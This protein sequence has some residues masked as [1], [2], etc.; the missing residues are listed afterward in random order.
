VDSE[1]RRRAWEASDSRLEINVPLVPKIF[2]LR[3]NIAKIMGYDTWADYIT[4]VKMVKSAQNALDVR[5]CYSACDL[6]VLIFLVSR[7]L[8]AEAPPS[9][10]Q[11]T[12]NITISQTSRMR[13]KGPAI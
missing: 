8:R 7:R 4:E 10:P 9:G 6:S 5:L 2:G 11:R 1:T 3:R 13:G 12:R